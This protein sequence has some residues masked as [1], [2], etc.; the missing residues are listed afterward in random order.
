MAGFGTPFQ[1]DIDLTSGYGH[2]YL[3]N[4]SRRPGTDHYSGCDTPELRCRLREGG[5]DALLVHGWHLKAYIQALLA[6]KRLSLPVIVRGDS[7]LET[8]RSM[9]KRVAKEIAYPPFLRLFDAALYVGIRSRAYYEHYR[10]P[11]ARMFF[12]PHCVDNNWFFLRATEASRRSLRSSLRIPD[13]VTVV[14]FAGRLVA[15]KRPLDVIAAAARARS[16]GGNVEVMIAG[17]GALRSQL[18]NEAA[19]SRVPLH[20]LG[21][22]NQSQM[23][24]VYSACDCLVLPSDGRET[25][26]LVVNEALACGRPIIVSDACGCAPDLAAG[27]TFPLGDTRA[28]AQRLLAVRA[29]QACCDTE[30]LTRTYSIEMA[31]EGI[32]SAVAQVTGA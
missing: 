22:C 4:T 29:S 17:D 24:E 28:L 30:S 19:S 26:G 18:T 2:S 1:W 15:F 20:F 25:W 10:Y 21:F 6:A 13:D 7:H 27:H 3:T 12:S 32:R 5:F 8:P 11:S 16:N 9:F 23:P 14:L 31:S